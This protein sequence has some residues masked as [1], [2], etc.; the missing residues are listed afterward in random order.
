[1]ILL[2]LIGR[3]HLDEL[4][5]ALDQSL[6]LR[7]IDFT[8]H[9]SFLQSK[10]NSLRPV[11]HPTGLWRRRRHANLQA[12]WFTQLSVYESAKDGVSRN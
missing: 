2:V 1:M 5:S 6:Q 3:Q 4:G 7:P 9:Q 12:L 11:G 8:W 10:E